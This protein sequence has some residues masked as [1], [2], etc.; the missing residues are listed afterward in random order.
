[1]TA[2]KVKVIKPDVFTGDCQRCKLFRPEGDD[3]GMCHRYPPSLFM[4]ED[5]MNFT[6]PVVNNDDFCGEFSPILS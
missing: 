1:M 6:F 3:F 5:G 4:D 2:K